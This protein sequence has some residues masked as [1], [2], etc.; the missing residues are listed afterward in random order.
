[1]ANPVFIEGNN[2]ADVIVTLPFRA[3]NIA[4][5]GPLAATYQFYRI[6]KVSVLYRP[7]ITE[8]NAPVGSSLAN[9]FTIPNIYVSE[10]HYSTT[11]TNLAALRDRGDVHMISSVHTFT[12]T[13]IPNTLIRVF[14][15]VAVDGFANMGTP[16]LSTA[17][18][19]VPHYG[20][21]IGIE[22]SSGGPVGLTFGGSLDIYFDISFKN[23]I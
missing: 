12:K 7:G 18:T 9:N 6:N 17:A 19:D 3:N 21:I 15:T 5:I 8:V 11:V 2:L 14:D 1:M 23:P 22:A 16:W 4:N 10:D 13:L 20:L